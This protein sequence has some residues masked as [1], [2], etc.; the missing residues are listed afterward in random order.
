M[1]EVRTRI[2]YI[3]VLAL[4]LAA[5]WAWWRY[6]L[7]FPFAWWADNWARVL[8]DWVT[9]EPLPPEAALTPR[10]M[11]SLYAAG[12]AIAFLWFALWVFGRRVTP[13]EHLSKAEAEAAAVGRPLPLPNK[14]QRKRLAASSA[15]NGDKTLLG[16]GYSQNCFLTDAMANRGTLAMGTTGSGKTV[17]VLNII[18]SFIAAGHPVIYVDGKG[19]RPL[20]EQIVNYAAARGVDTHLFAMTPDKFKK[21]SAYNPLASGTPTQ[22]KDRIIAYGEWSEAHYKKL[23]EGYLQIVFTVLHD[24]RISVGMTE[25]DGYMTRDR[26]T[27]EVRSAVQKGGLPEG[28]GTELLNKIASHAEGE[29]HSAGLRADIANLAESDISHLLGAKGFNIA[30]ALAG[31]KTVYFGLSPAQYSKVAP[32]LGRLIVNDLKAATMIDRRTTLLVFDE[33]SV[34]PGDQILH[35][36][37][38]G[39]SFGLCTVL[40]VQSLSDIGRTLGSEAEAFTR[41]VLGNCNNFLIHRLNT[42]DDADYTAKLIG[43][44]GTIDW[45]TK[46]GKHG[47]AK[48][49]SARQIHKLAVHP[50]KI[51]RL[52]DGQAVFYQKPETTSEINVRKSRI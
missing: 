9:L 47:N 30:E 41:Q 7:D 42:P 10:H 37:N 52:R 48:A 3:F 49:S 39:R 14:K 20:G 18:E 4:V 16:R 29:K 51:K 27:A 25:L 31:G 40:T 13:E 33:F 8:V 44:Y 26:L 46:V 50:D 36:L 38:Q 34:F 19:D 45:T 11:A 12:G 32:A 21:T 23:A 15:R 35:I 28:R 2:A 43:T 17:T 22:L 1:R 24:C 6:V 5:L